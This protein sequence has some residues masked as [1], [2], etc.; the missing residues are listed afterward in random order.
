M[1]RRL[2]TRVL[3]SLL[4]AACLAFSACS[5]D[6]GPEVV[7]DSG[8]PPID[9]GVILDNGS[10]GDSAPAVPCACPE[11]EICNIHD[12]CIAKP[13]HQGT[14]VVAELVLLNQETPLGTDM[15]AKL[16]K[17]ETSIYAHEPLPTDTRDVYTTPEGESCYFESGG[18]MYPH[19]Y[20]GE[21][22]PA[23]PGLGAGNLTFQVTGGPSSIIM[24]TMDLGAEYGFGYYHNTVPPPLSDGTVT[25]AD[26][27]D[28]VNVP[29]GAD[30]TVQ[31]AGGPDVASASFSGGKLPEAF[32]ITSPAVETPN[33]TAPAGTPLTVAWSPP[34]P[35]AVME[36]FIT[37]EAGMGSLSLLSCMLTDDGSATIPA[38]AL[39]QFSGYS[40]V[41]LQLRR[42]VS[43]YQQAGASQGRTLH[44]YLIGRHARL[45][46]FS[47]GN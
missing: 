29:L 11:G 30:F 32:T 10:T 8:L 42:T 33:A 5:D 47:L 38:A 1:M 14:D 23:G 45:G 13:T 18:S 31:A 15:L 37:A 44:L 25:Y 24:E 35:S 26:F 17:A 27:F 28:V 20:D 4:T 36:V 9:S 22:W 6:T 21:Y 3:P 7:P 40:T 41:G 19:Y 12:K 16:G 39:A 2:I 46:S 43:R 34:Q